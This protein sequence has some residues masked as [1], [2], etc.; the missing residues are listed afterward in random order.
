MT[1]EHLADPVPEDEQDLPVL[2]ASGDQPAEVYSAEEAELIAERLAA[3]GY[4]E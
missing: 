3:L 1:S 4:I 2:S